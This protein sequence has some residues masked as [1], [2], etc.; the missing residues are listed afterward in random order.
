MAT[1][2]IVVPAYNVE[3]EI[4]RCLSSI[5]VQSFTD[6]E[7]IVV[8]DCS[9]DNTPAE[10]EKAIFQD[11][12]F[13]VIRHEENKG[14]HLARKTG[15]SAARGQYLFF[16]DGDDEITQNY[17][18][19]LS[20][21]ISGQ[22]AELFHV[23]ITVLND[24]VTEGER[25]GFEKAGNRRSEPLQGAQISHLVFDEEAGYQMDWRVTSRIFKTEFAKQ[26]FDH[27][28][29]R[30]L[31]RAEDAY[32]S[33][34][35]FALNPLQ[36]PLESCRGYLYH[37]GGGISGS[38][39][40]SPQQF[41]RNCLQFEGC[42]SAVA[43]FIQNPS[44]TYLDSAYRGLRNKLHEQIG[45][46]FLYRVADADKNGALEGAVKVCG[47]PVIA[48]ELWRHVRDAYYAL[49]VNDYTD[50]EV[51]HAQFLASLAEVVVVSEASEEDFDRFEAMRHIARSHK[52]DF[53]RAVVLQTYEEQPVKI[54]VTT[55]KDVDVPQGAVHQPVQVGAGLKNNRFM[56][57]YHDDEGDNIEDKNP[58]YCEMT[59]QYWAWKNAL[60]NASYVGFCHYRRYFNFSNTTYE[61]NPFGEVIDDY[62][63]ADAI[64][65]Y[66]LDDKSV[67][68]AVEGYD[69]ITTGFHDLRNMPGHFSTPREHYAQAPLLH[70]KDIDRMVGI[71][72]RLYPDYVADARAFLNGHKSCFCNMYI[73]RTEIFER[74]CE[75]LFPI[76]DAYTAQTD[77]STYSKEALRTPGHLAERLFNI[78]YHH[79]QRTHAGWKTKELQCVH[80]E[81]PDRQQPLPPIIDLEPKARGRHI[82]PVV[83]ASDD[84]YVPML[85][86]T[87]YSMLTNAN[88]EPFYDVVVL[89][90]NMS[91]QR[92]ATL[93][94]MVSAFGNARLR[95]VNVQRM[96]EGYDLSTNNEHISL[97]TYY[98]FLVQKI[99][100]AYDKVLYLDSD[101]VVEGDVYQLFSCELGTNLLAAAHDIDY[102]GNLNMNDGARLHYTTEVLGLAHPY[103]YFQAG[104]LVLNTAELRQLHSVEEWMHIVSNANYIY[105][106]QDIL[107]KE[108]EGRVTYLPFEWNVMHDCAGR[109]GNVF[110]FA[111][112]YMFDAYMAS[113]ANPQIVHYA[114]FEK[115]WVNLR[116][117]FA[118]TYWHY[119]RQTP[120]YEEFVGR[121]AQN[122]APAPAPQPTQSVVDTS[123]E[124][125]LPENSPLRR[126]V[127]PLMPVGTK[128]R[129]VFKSLGRSLQGKK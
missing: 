115:P 79:A 39:T 13:V 53:D 118:T 76:L 111:P 120:F 73:M 4:G 56:W 48:R 123:H 21:G 38:S 75:W 112:N 72:A 25:S 129:E 107:N 31:E 29:N 8:D 55:H 2:S 124:K 52:N 42:L 63:D 58:L 126:Y 40:M 59:V 119:A 33:F 26:A 24:G 7:V 86:T 110:A 81:Q 87:V 109:V 11:S 1:F 113:R 88:P 41:E 36:L 93:E 82:V 51:A 71:I 49:L 5:R 18:E 68:R 23:G 54:F 20:Q 65:K 100:G 17:L 43:E 106:D 78:Y 80:F 57:A 128:R 14:L 46:D 74:Y 121:I 66:A 125:A 84:N 89:E 61:E 19:Q 34:V 103:D 117:D 85:A 37:Y 45:T 9:T 95:F 77:M 44:Y 62:I 15:V 116:A 30:R 64:K 10:I 6:F 99:L 35:C 102:L 47:A 60:K 127:D 70:I 16:L 104:V 122:M 101:L 27:M 83:F 98:R 3:R 12:R 91:G 69:V 22:D 94:H 32:E 90:R 108:C 92:K 28:V 50:A 105:D 67:L 114:G 96:I 97:E